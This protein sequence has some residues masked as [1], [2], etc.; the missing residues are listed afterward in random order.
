MGGEDVHAAMISAATV[1]GVAKE[2]QDGSRVPLRHRKRDGCVHTKLDVISAP[3][4][5]FGLK[6]HDVFGSPS[7]DVLDTFRKGSGRQDG[8]GTAGRVLRHPVH[9]DEDP[10]RIL[11]IQGRVDGQP[12]ATSQL[13]TIAPSLRRL[14]KKESLLFERKGDGR[15]FPEG[16]RRGTDPLCTQSR[17]REL[18]GT[19]GFHIS[20]VRRQ[21]PK[22]VLNLID[23]IASV[24]GKNGQAGPHRPSR[25]RGAHVPKTLHVDMAF[26]VD[27][28]FTMRC[29]SH[30]RSG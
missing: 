21:V 9:V 29:D 16:P 3:V 26:H 14:G 2:A 22:L 11:A 25:G 5:E 6:A 17:L 24:Q 23:L 8:D 20:F 4:E 18:H 27:I 30:C 7:G 12:L 28:A 13:E 1:P 10:E 19:Q 15:S